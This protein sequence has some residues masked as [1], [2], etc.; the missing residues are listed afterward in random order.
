MNLQI[1]VTASD[2]GDV[3]MGASQLRR[4]CEHHQVNRIALSSPPPFR[5]LMIDN[6]TILIRIL[7]VMSLAVS[8]GVEG[9][10]R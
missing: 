10:I 8:S 2:C 7:K 3:D 9:V 5:D 4:R 1:Q 6:C